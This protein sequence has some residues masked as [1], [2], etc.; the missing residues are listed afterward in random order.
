MN[1]TFDAVAFTEILEQLAGYA[2]SLQAKEKIYNLVPYLDEGELRRNMR[3]TTQARQMLDLLGTPPLPMMEQ[4]GHLVE[5]AV[6]GE[7]LLPE[8]MEEIGMFLA[9]VRRMQSYLERG[10]THRIPA[11]YY[12]ENL[13]PLTELKEEINRSIRHGQIDDHASGALW[14]IRKDLRVLEEKIK[15]KA[16][17]LLKTQKKYMAE[18]FV[19]TR[20]H[21]LCLPVKKEYKA[22]IPGSVID[23][24]STGATIFIEPEAVA[25][26]QDEREILK[27]EEDCEE[28][29]IL[30]TLMD[31]I[32]DMEAPIKG[33]LETLAKL[34]FIFAKGKMSAQMD[35]GEPL[36]NTE[37]RIVLKDARHPL[38]PGESNVPLQF[39][40]GGG[41][42]GMII[43]GPNTGGKT[44]AIKTVGLFVLMA[45]CGLHLPCSY[46]DVAMRNRVLCDIGD[47]QNLADNLSTFSA[48]ITNVLDILRRATGDSLVIL[49]ELG[50]GTDP[51]EGMGIAIAI[52]EELRRRGCLYLVTTHYPEV[53]S[54][55]RKHE[56]IIS[57]RMAFD[58]EN[59]KPLYR[60]E[61]GKSGDSCALYIAKRLGMPGHMLQMAAEEAY[62]GVREELRKELGLDCGGD[63]LERIYEPGITVIKKRAEAKDVSSLFARGDSVSVEPSGEAGIV[64]RPADLMGNVLVQVKKEKRTVNYKRLKLLVK[65]SQLYPEDYDFSIIFDTVENRKARHDME[66][67]YQKDIQVQVEDY[68]SGNVEGWS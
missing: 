22:R 20:N 11:A 23:T 33:N 32:A 50:S 36:I 28:R 44:V 60:L 49:D 30:Y 5:K 6:L 45:G 48:H 27:I 9:A 63:E 64:V 66:R 62:S 41:S 58:R 34:D 10:K 14:G 43:T 31:M 56:E 55:A 19:V 24:S 38:L 40:I 46:G 47:G 7:L 51:A 59:L 4:V 8:E 65:A 57:A 13:Q 1:Q 39:E 37:G 21:R 3:D 2:N 12:S 29:K 16:E 35:A 61:M 67:K 26:L 53:K 68:R 17:A 18:A 52:L 42:R 54:Y 15:V 25:R